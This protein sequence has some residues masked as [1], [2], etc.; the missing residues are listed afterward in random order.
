M[1]ISYDLTNVK[2]VVN[3]C[4]PSLSTFAGPVTYMD[5]SVATR[6]IEECLHTLNKEWQ[7]A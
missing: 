6:V 3:F 7:N 5:V 4:V 2:N 1:I